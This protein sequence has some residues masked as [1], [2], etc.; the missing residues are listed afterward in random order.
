MELAAEQ[1]AV[2]EPAVRTINTPVVRQ[3]LQSNVNLYNSLHEVTLRHP[4][5]APGDVDLKLA[6]YFPSRMLH[7]ASAVFEMGCGCFVRARAWT[8]LDTCLF[9]PT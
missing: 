1:L 5:S 3:R 2:L 7:G 9:W 6:L 8:P 4:D